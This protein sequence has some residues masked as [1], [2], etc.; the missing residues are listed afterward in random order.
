MKRHLFSA[1][2]L[3]ALAV[4]SVERDAEAFCGFYVGGDDAK[5]FNNATMVA[6]MRDGTRT[7]LSMQNNY[8][9][10]ASKFAMVIPVPVVLQKDNVKTLKDEVF[11]RLDQLAAP[12]LVEYWEQ[13]PCRQLEAPE[14]EG[15]SAAMAAAPGGARKSKGGGLGVKI[16]AQFDVGEYEIV[17]LSAKDSSGLETWLKQNEYAIPSGAEEVLRP[18]VKDGMKFFVAKINPEK[19]V[20]KNG[21]AKLSPLRFHYDSE[22]F[23]LPV[24]LGLLN[25]K[26]K[27]DLIVHILAPSKRYEVAN[28]KNVT[29]P[30]NI[31]VKEES[32]PRFGELYAALFDQTLEKNPG[33]VVTEYSWDAG[34]CDPCPVPALNR[35]ELMSLGQDILDLPAGQ[36]LTPGSTPAPAASALKL[37]DRLKLGKSRVPPPAGMADK[38]SVAKPRRVPALRRRFRSFVLTRIHARYDKTSLKEDLVFR[39]AKPITGGR[40]VKRNGRLEE[41]STPASRN[42]FQ[43]RYIIRH[44]W[45]GPIECKNPVRGVWGGPPSGQ[46]SNPKAATDL[47]FAKRGALQLAKHV[48]TSVPELGIQVTPKPEPKQ[49]AKTAAPSTRSDGSGCGACRIGSPSEPSKSVPWGMFGLSLLIGRRLRRRVRRSNRAPERLT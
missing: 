6:M 30:T 14:D 39:E 49:V 9:G 31:E 46:R 47:A 7:V 43:A 18:Y 27:Q 24:R 28:Y 2:L 44:P 5:L 23:T 1:A 22:K 26:D 4:T 11:S 42:N 3:C 32:K 20:F 8:Q 15:E 19:V 29:I 12:R 25:A 35:G 37:S 10:P 41:G 34:T 13:D 36:S 48:N 40:E 33:S 21:Q 45:K 38:I 17:I 16:E